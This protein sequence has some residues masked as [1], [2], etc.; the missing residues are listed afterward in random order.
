M[1][2]K[3]WILMILL[4]LVVLIPDMCFMMFQKVFYPT[5]TDAVM[6]LQNK[7]PDYVYDGFKDVFIPGLPQ[8]DEEA[9]AKQVLPQ[10]VASQDD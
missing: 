10:N 1:T 4:P 9:N 8:K 5:P 7:D 6:V 3:A 2:G